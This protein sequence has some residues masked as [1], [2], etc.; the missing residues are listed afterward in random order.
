MMALSKPA[1]ILSAIGTRIGK[2]PGWERVVRRLIPPEHCG[3]MGA[4]RLA[5]DGVT[6]MTRPSH[7]LGWNVTF[8]GSYEPELRRIFR[9]VLPAGGTAIDV[10]ANTGWHTLLLARLAG[11]NGRVLAVE[12]NPS[13]RVDLFENLEFNGFDRVEVIAA[14]LSDAEGKLDFYGPAADDPGSGSGH[15]ATNGGGSAQTYAVE[16]AT[17]DKIVADAKLD[18]LH[19]LK[20]DVEGFEWPVLKGGARTIAQ[21]RPHI[22]F[23]YDAETAARGGATPALLDEFFRTHRYKPMQ[24]G[25][26]EPRPI[27]SGHW[28]TWANVWAAPLD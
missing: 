11:E 19:L 10:G 17:L 14:A 25:R 3:E 1:Q 24:T 27:R 2:P 8:F 9:A 23:E 6:F 18:R 13:V 16:C 5:R 12:P 21:F 7:F 22:V 15:V 4:L 28:P 20:I 26:G